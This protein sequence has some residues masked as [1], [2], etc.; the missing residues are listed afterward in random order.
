MKIEIRF[1][2]WLRLAYRFILKVFGRLARAMALYTGPGFATFLATWADYRQHES[3]LKD[4]HFP[5]TFEDCNLEHLSKLEADGICVIEGFWSEEKCAFGRSEVDRIIREYP[6][7]LHSSAKADQRVYGANNVSRL[8]DS[9]AQN[10]VLLSVASAYNRELT[11]TAFTLAARMPASKGN[12]GSGE[13][14]HRDAFLR[15][16]KAILYLSEVGLDNGPFQYVK[17]SYRPAQVLKDLRRGCLRYMQNRLSQP[18]VDR[19]VEGFPERIC[20]YTA[21]AG[22]LILVDTSGIHRG[23]PINEGT[24]YAL[25]NYYYPQNRI[26]K[27]MSTKF[28]VLPKCDLVPAAE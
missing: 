12:E 16:F 4:A 8:I 17:D 15:Q 21:K 11:C 5:S 28:Q 10:P 27:E 25:T 2:S 6:D 23:M 26:D 19:I 13:G 18:E 24:R 20:T 9:F 3:R 7:A 22:T 1:S 14:W